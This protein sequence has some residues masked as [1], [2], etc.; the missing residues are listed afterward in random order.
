[1]ARDAGSEGWVVL[2]EKLRGQKAL[3]SVITQILAMRLNL[4]R[5]KKQDYT[6]R[7]CHKHKAG[8]H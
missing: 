3:A 6:N 5:A 4:F 7:N 8:R 1:L 2:A